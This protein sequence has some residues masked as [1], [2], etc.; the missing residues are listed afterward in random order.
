[1]AEGIMYQPT[2]SDSIEE[3]L[4]HKFFDVLLS[5]SFFQHTP[6]SES[7]FV[8]HDLMNDLATSVAVAA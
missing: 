7:L 1:M 2:P 5:G 3:R 4:G 8:M 6:N